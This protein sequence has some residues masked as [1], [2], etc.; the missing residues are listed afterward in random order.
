MDCVNHTGVAA[1]AYCQSCGKALCDGCVRKAAGGQILCEPCWMAWQS[2]QQPFVAP[3]PGGPHPGSP[4]SWVF[5]PAWA[6]C[7]TASFS[8]AS[9]TWRSSPCWSRIANHYDVFGIIVAAWIIYSRL[10]PTTP[11]RLCATASPCLIR[12]D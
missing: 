12:W 9:S 6:P 2:Y 1:T 7:T 4:H 10:R 5:F 8:K 11:P 3:H